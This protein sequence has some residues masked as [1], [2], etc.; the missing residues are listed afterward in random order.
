MVNRLE[1]AAST[2]WTDGELAVRPLELTT[3]EM[4]V[5]CYFAEAIVV[6]AAAAN[7]ALAAT[8]NARAV[9]AA[10]N[11]W[12][13]GHAVDIGGFQSSGRLTGAGPGISA[14]SVTDLLGFRESGL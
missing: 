11:R 1:L 5:S 6:A 3:P 7:R 14:G 8:E 12:N 10:G 2:Q 4:P 9:A 13:A